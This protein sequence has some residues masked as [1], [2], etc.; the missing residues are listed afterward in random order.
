[1]TQFNLHPPNNIFESVALN[2]IAQSYNRVNGY[3]FGQNLVVSLLLSHAEWLF[4]IP[5]QPQ[6]Y[7]ILYLQTYLFFISGSFLIYFCQ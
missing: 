2:S 5:E 6:I 1:M 7:Q 3:N 4:E